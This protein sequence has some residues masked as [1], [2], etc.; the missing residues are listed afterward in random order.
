MPGP[1]NAELVRE[2]FDKIEK[3]TK[4]TLNAH[5][6][7]VFLTPRT[8]TNEAEFFLRELKNALAKGESCDMFFLPTDNDVIDKITDEGLALDLSDLFAQYAPRYYNRV[9]EGV[10]NY[11]EFNKLIS[12]DESFF[13]AYS[14]ELSQPEDTFVAYMA[15]RAQ[16]D[17][18]NTFFIKD[19]NNWY[20][21][22]QKSNESGGSALLMEA[23]LCNIDSTTTKPKLKSEELDFEAFPNPVSADNS[24]FL[25][26]FK[27]DVEPT[28]VSIYDLSGRLISNKYSQPATKWL[29]IDFTGFKTGT[30]FVHIE[31][32][33]KIYKT[34]VLNL[35]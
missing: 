10:M 16:V 24:T 9:D 5:F 3:Q 14:M 11:F 8:F 33:D 23:V 19:G 15:E 22:P 27:Q 35:Q 18:H 13:I 1:R 30:Y 26:N 29:S 20:S 28:K 34:K 21:F 4:K 25:L 7:F 31:T 6:E 17:P 2:A 32:V 12:V